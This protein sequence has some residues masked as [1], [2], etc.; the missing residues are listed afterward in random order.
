MSGHSE[1]GE[2]AE[3]KTLVMV[4]IH[5]FRSLQD[6]FEARAS[7]WMLTCA[8]ISLGFVFFLNNGMFHT[9]SFEGL[10]N[11]MNDQYVW[12][13]LF[14]VVGFARLSVLIINGAYWRTPHFRAIGAFLCAGI[15]FIFC[16]GFVRNGS[17]LT[18]VMP[19]IFLLDAYNVKRASREAGKSEFLQRY[20]RNREAVHAGLIRGTHP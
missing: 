13:V 7:E 11:L 9:T 12:A 16:I 18:A 14:T 1:M 4:V 6:S 10:R 20:I 3:R 8:T 5:S 2:R 19:W 17:I 15:W